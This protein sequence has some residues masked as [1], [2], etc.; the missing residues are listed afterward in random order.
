M[1]DGRARG[2]RGTPNRVHRGGSW[3]NPAENC[4]SAYRNRRH[5]GNRNPDLGFRPAPN[6]RPGRR[7]VSTDAVP[8]RDAY[9]PGSGP[10]GP[11]RWMAAA[12]W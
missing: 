3:N 7:T 8:D 12:G 9:S 4:R 1:V 2:E 5:P 6:A 10:K 11:N